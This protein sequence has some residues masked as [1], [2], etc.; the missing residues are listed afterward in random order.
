M[1]KG[2]VS[3]LT[4]VVSLGLVGAAYAQEAYIGARY[5]WSRHKTK[6]SAFGIRYKS[7]YSDAFGVQLGLR[8]RHLGIEA[9]YYETDHFLN[10]LATP[11]AELDVERLELSNIGLNVIYFFSIPYLEPYVTAGYASYRVNVVGL[12]KDKSGG[13]NLGLGLS[14]RL[15]KSIS[16][17]VEGKYHWVDFIIKGDTL[18]L[19]DL[20]LSLS[21]NYYF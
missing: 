8:G 17:V 3:V 18:E 13:F 16:L 12:Q 7:D 11:P 9:N 6:F 19:N 10:P 4:L 21:F 14:L 20:F 5:G 1:K 2:A 15:L